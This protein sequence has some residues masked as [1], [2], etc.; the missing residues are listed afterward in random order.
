[1]SETAVPSADERE[2][3]EYLVRHFGLEAGPHPGGWDECLCCP[4]PDDNEIETPHAD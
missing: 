2:W 4:L 1:M 3:I